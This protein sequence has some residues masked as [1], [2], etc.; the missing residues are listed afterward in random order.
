MK[1]AEMP[2]QASQSLSLLVWGRGKRKK[3]GWDGL[4]SSE[5]PPI[6]C[7]FI[8]EAFSWVLKLLIKKIISQRKQPRSQHESELLINTKQ[9]TALVKT[10]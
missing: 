6:E 9:N 2:L 8:T 5:G 1:W 3:G 7:G 4:Q 10:P